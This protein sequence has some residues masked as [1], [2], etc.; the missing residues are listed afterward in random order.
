MLPTTLKGVWVRTER[1]IAH[2]RPVVNLAVK[3]GLGVI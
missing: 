1:R 2:T 3:V